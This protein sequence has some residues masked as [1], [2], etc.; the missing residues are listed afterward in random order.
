MSKLSLH[1]VLKNSYDTKNKQKNAFKN[2]GFVYDSDLSNH[3]HQVY[4]NPKEKKMLY[5]VKGTNLF[6][7]KDIGTD[8][9]LA[10]GHL[11]DTSR[12]IEEKN[13][14]EKAKKRYNPT[15]TTIAGHSLG[16]TLSQYI[17]G[18][19]DKVFTLDKGATI[20]QKTR[21]NETAY[22]TQGDAVSALNVNSKRMTTLKNPYWKTG[23]IPLD[24]YFSHDVDNI[25]GK[26]IFV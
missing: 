5:S 14:L 11:K 17:A 1:K 3:E 10:S 22:R 23:I 8:I 24:A 6:S 4:Y 25:K 9:Y 16:A 20:G 19:N 2:D 21:S 7:P 12:F 15:N 26:N 18:K 13:N